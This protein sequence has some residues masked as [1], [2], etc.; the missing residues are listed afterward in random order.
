M[1]GIGA[2]DLM[3][4]RDACTCMMDSDSRRPTPAWSDSQVIFTGTVLE[5]DR[6]EGSANEL[7]QQVRL[8]VEDSWRGAARDTVTINVY[9]DS[10]CAQYMAGSRYLVLAATPRADTDPLETYPCHF[11][12]G[13]TYPQTKKFLTELGPPRRRSPAPGS[14][15]IDRD[16]TRVGSAAPLHAVVVNVGVGIASMSDVA[17]VAVAGQSWSVARNGAPTFKLAEGLYHVRID[18]RDGGKST[19]T[20]LS[21]RCEEGEPPGSCY[22]FR[23]LSGHREALREQH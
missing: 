1:T 5:V 9:Q 8:L 13:L 4:T 7:S 14:R 6:P 12:W 19:F 23:Y 3:P 2:P 21:V 15:E 16:V 22:T 17:A 11:A 18:W 20:Y 10:P